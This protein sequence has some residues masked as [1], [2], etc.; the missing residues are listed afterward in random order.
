MKKKLFKVLSLFLAVTFVFLNLPAGVLAYGNTIQSKIDDSKEIT[1]VNEIEE[2]INEDEKETKSILPLILS[3]EKSL[4]DEYSKFYLCDDNSMVSITFAEPV[5]T[6][7][8]DEEW[9]DI[10]E[11]SQVLRDN[12]I[13]LNCDNYRINITAEAKVGE[14]TAIKLNGGKK[15]VSENDNSKKNNGLF[16]SSAIKAMSKA[17]KEDLKKGVLSERF[18]GDKQKEEAFVENLNSMIEHYNTTV[19][20]SVR[21]N[22]KEIEFVNPFDD[23]TSMQYYV[24]NKTIKENLILNDRSEFVSYSSIIDC[25]DF[26]PVLK[27]NGSIIFTDESNNIVFYIT[28]P[29]MYDSVGNTSTEIEIDIQPTLT[30]YRITYTPNA[31]WL[32]SDDTIY[33]VTIDP[34]Y[35]SGNCLPANFEQTFVSYSNPDSYY[36]NYRYMCVGNAGDSNHNFGKTY[37]YFWVK[38]MPSIHG[39][40]I[41][42]SYIT[43]SVLN[44]AGTVHNLDAYIPESQCDFAEMTW[45]T[46]PDASEHLIKSNI[47]AT[48]KSGSSTQYQYTIPLGILP[49]NWYF[50]TDARRFGVML[51]YSNT[52]FQD[53]TLLYGSNSRNPSSCYPYLVI[54][55]EP[56]PQ[57]SAEI[58]LVIPTGDY[59]IANSYT[60]NYLTY[61]SQSG[62]LDTQPYYDGN[63][64]KWHVYQNS[65]GTYSFYPLSNTNLRLETHCGTYTD[66]RPLTLYDYVNTNN[67][68]SNAIRYRICRS[69]SSTY[70]IKPVSKTSLAVSAY[71]G[72]IGTDSFAYFYNNYNSSYRTFDKKAGENTQLYAYSA[73]IHQQWY[74]QPVGQYLE[75]NESISD[76]LYY[77]YSELYQDYLTYDSTDNTA[78]IGEVG[79]GL[80]QQWMVRCQSDGTYTISPQIKRE[81]SLDLH[82][83]ASAVGIPLTVS[84]YVNGSASVNRKMRFHDVTYNSNGNTYTA[85]IS[86][87]L[88]PMESLDIYVGG[89][90]NWSQGST[91][92]QLVGSESVI[93]GRT[94]NA[95]SQKWRFVRVLEYEADNTL[96]D[97]LIYQLG[98]LRYMINKTY[99]EVSNLDTRTSMIEELELQEDLI[100]ADYILESN[101]YLSSYASAVIPDFVPFINSAPQ[102]AAGYPDIY[103]VVANRLLVMYG[104]VNEGEN[105]SAAYLDDNCKYN[106]WTE[107]SNSALN[108]YF[109]LTNGSTFF[110]RTDSGIEAVERTNTLIERLN[111]FRYYH[112]EVKQFCA[113]ALDGQ[114]EVGIPKGSS[115]GTY[116]GFADIVKSNGYSGSYIWEVKPN[117]Q[118]YYIHGGVQGIGTKQLGRYINAANTALQVKKKIFGGYIYYQKPFSAGFPLQHFDFILPSIENPG[119]TVT[120]DVGCPDYSPLI[121]PDSGLILYRKKGIEEPS[122]SIEY[123]YN[124][125]KVELLQSTTLVIQLDDIVEG[126][127][128]ILG[129]Q[130]VGAVV[131]STVLLYLAAPEVGAALS[132]MAGTA[133]STVISNFKNVSFIVTTF[134]R[135]LTYYLNRLYDPAYS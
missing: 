55:Y 33:P 133:S 59:V 99:D 28:S 8:D 108:W 98:V 86:P 63:T 46:K 10:E 78:K 88:S 44:E 5:H 134:A 32:S 56:K 102:V 65:D 109:L 114:C 25:L 115:D 77:L 1:S 30:G 126:N 72:E 71:I 42:N 64:Q 13:T 127:T 103:K 118:K 79:Y 60:G 54:E 121:L 124:D 91:E 117:N 15:R 18:D 69:S 111:I 37:S 112:N 106:E 26:K 66:Y 80:S 36:G 97:N 105:E 128:V 2:Q 67:L 125:E 38:N 85:S 22:K 35:V 21:F 81:R 70:S 131:L 120:L 74:F 75:H 3:E 52:G 17:A 113:T 68:D 110:N 58:S 130:V 43:L 107:E 129:A 47:Q 50:S 19:F 73:A 135:E 93:L 4:R 27:E 62:T 104:T 9:I 96:P 51:K 61:N 40:T 95:T 41:K 123:S 7:N 84:S 87:A 57:E 6:L 20:E 31:E 11:N 101:N 92:V 12:K 122:N 94:N 24:T 45:N 16:V 76:G 53:F 49:V 23:N 119:E 34:E 29:V 39:G 89:T 83:G 100:R 116:Y 48:L 90:I 14:K 132:I 82:N